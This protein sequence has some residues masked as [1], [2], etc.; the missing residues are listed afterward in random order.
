MLRLP[1]IFFIDFAKP[2]LLGEYGRIAKSLLSG[3]GYAYPWTRLDGSTVILPTAYMPPGQ[4]FVQYLTFSVFGDSHSGIIALYLFQALEACAFIYLTGKIAELLFGS[5]K[6]TRIV[7]W[8]AALYP[9][10][11]YTTL[12]FGIAS[13]TLLLNA[14]ILYTGIQFSAALR[15]TSERLKFSLIFGAASGLLLLYRGEA[16]LIIVT[17]LLLILYRN[18][19]KISVALRYA[20]LAMVVAIAMLAPWTLR[21]Y[22]VFQRL[23]PIST[24]GGFNLWRG[25]NAL[26]TGI[27][28]WPT[29]EL[30]NKIEPALDTA[31]DFDKVTSDIYT[32]EALE[33]IERNPV[34][35]ITLSGKKA[36]ILWTVDIQSNRGYATMVFLGIYGCTLIALGF[37]I[38]RIWRLHV[39]RRDEYAAAGFGLIILSCAIATFLAM[40]FF[41]MPRFQILLTGIYFPVAG[42]GLSEMIALGRKAFYA[43]T[44]FLAR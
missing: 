21:N 34:A 24:N 23:I 25:N 15:L 16:P 43:R 38:V 31:H 30:R 5:D 17:I 8:S 7:I 29:E 10:F 28:V 18:R 19:N 36:L 2:D 42:Y 4:V 1:G 40:V 20:G 11:F 44:V 32:H 27:P 41:P 39:S 3:F 37:G 13:T 35:T 14:L 6:V 33:W 26:T 12:T 9:P 22:I